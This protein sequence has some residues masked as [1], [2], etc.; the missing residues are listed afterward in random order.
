MA[1]KLPHQVALLRWHL[2]PTIHTGETAVRLNHGG[3]KKII[4]RADLFRVSSV[5]RSGARSGARSVGAIAGAA[6]A[7]SVVDRAALKLTRISLPRGR[8]K[9]LLIASVASPSE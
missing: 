1:N 3:S 9:V 6:G 8:M 7:G 2:R 5:S 4:A